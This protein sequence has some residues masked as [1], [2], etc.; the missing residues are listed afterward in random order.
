MHFLV[1]TSEY[2]M[3]TIVEYLISRTMVNVRTGIKNIVTLYA[4]CDFKLNVINTDN[5]FTAFIG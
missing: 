2:I 4:R 5:E 1:S 3:F